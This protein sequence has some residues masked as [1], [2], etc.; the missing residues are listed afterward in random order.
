MKNETSKTKTNDLF[1]TI[2]LSM[3]FMKAYPVKQI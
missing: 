3:F 1:N 2:V